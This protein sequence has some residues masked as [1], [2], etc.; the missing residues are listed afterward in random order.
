MKKI[1]VLALTRMAIPSVGFA[2]NLARHSNLE[3]ACSA[4]GSGMD[5]RCVGDT[6]PGTESDALS[7]RQA[8]ALG[9][10]EMAP[11]QYRVQR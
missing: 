1:A 6:L 7:T 9:M 11:A 10:H 8:R 5:P 4:S 3:P 2:Q